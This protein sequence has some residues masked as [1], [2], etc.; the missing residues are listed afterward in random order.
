MWLLMMKP[1]W[2][3]SAS[4]YCNTHERISFLSPPQCH[5]TRYAFN[6]CGTYPHPQTF[7]SAFWVLELVVQHVFATIFHSNEICK[8]QARSSYHIRQ[9]QAHKALLGPDPLQDPLCL[10]KTA[11]QFWY[12][13]LCFA[14]MFCRQFHCN[15]SAA[16]CRQGPSIPQTHGNRLTRHPS[17]LLGPD[18]HKILCVSSRQHTVLICRALFCKYVFAVNSIAMNLLQSASK[19]PP[20]HKP[21]AAGSQGI[22]LLFLDQI[23]CKIPCVSS[24]QPSSQ[25]PNRSSINL[26]GNETHCC[27]LYW[28]KTMRTARF[29]LCPVMGGASSQ[30]SCF[31]L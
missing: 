15:E 31:L 12:L 17:P 27:Q 9:H 16:T 21:R 10:I 8:L 2:Q 29:S 4:C 19:V 26:T 5:H 25:M 23:L 28:I 1:K 30:S 22:L 7:T 11:F 3:Y 24:R 14:N 18:P 13:E 6:V 20:Y